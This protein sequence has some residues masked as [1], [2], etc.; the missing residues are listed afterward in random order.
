MNGKKIAL[1]LPYSYLC[2]HYEGERDFILDRIFGPADLMLSRLKN[3]LSGI[4]ISNF[5]ETVSASSI[6]CAVRRI[7][8]HGLET[9]IHAYLPKELKGNKLT[10]IYPWLQ[11]L[12]PVIRDIQT[13][14]LLNIHALVIDGIEREVLLKMSIENLKTLVPILEDTDVP[15]FVAIELNR[16]KNNS[17]PSINYENLLRI[18]REVNN[19]RF[20]I[21]WDL[22]HTY[23]NVLNSV[24]PLEPPQE[25]IERVIHIH[26]HDLNEKG[27]THWPLTI[28]TLPLN[29]YLKKLRAV[30]Y[31]GYYT[32]ELYP[33]RFLNCH[34]PAEE[35]LES[36]E[37]LSCA[38]G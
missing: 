18:C 16:M 27:Q 26:I 29:Y 37:I 20:G 33:E 10:R 23:S 19:H 35:I 38:H 32:L 25:F 21:G 22:G 30:N 2:N 17:D 12:V 14:L 1:S 28:G 5:N 8:R 3:R 13:Q 34:S 11:S 24:I 15:I 4:E 9:I 36:I 6:T 7:L 31:C